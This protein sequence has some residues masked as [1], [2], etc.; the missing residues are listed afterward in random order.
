M[1]ASIGSVT[2][3]PY[4]QVDGIQNGRHWHRLGRRR[5]TQDLDLG[6]ALVNETV[7]AEVGLWNIQFG[8]P[9][10]TMVYSTRVDSLIDLQSVTDALM[11]N[12]KH[13]EMIAKGSQ[14]QAGPPVDSLSDPLHGGEGDVSP[15][16][17]VVTVTQAVIANS[18]AKAAEWGVEVSIPADKVIGRTFISMTATAR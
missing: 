3:G 4:P 8:Q 13:H 11:G 2:A 12:P 1:R 14:Y 10:E 18:Y 15:V 5:Q 6:T 9:A 17:A 16:G 7:G